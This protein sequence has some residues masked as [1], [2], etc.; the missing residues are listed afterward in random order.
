MN[1]RTELRQRLRQQAQ[2]KKT[3]PTRTLE[4]IL[5]WVQ[6]ALALT[7]LATACIYL[8]GMAWH[9]G[10]VNVF[11]VDSSEFPLSTEQTLLVGTIALV[12]NIAPYISYPLAGFA[13][14]LVLLVIAAFTS[15]LLKRLYNWHQ[16]KMLRIDDTIRQSSTFKMLTKNAIKPQDAPI[17]EAC[18]NIFLTLFTRYSYIIGTG[19]I[20]FL[21]TIYSFSNGK[22]EA[23]SQ[24]NKMKN[25]EYSSA[26]C[27]KYAEHPEE[28]SALRIVCNATQCTFWTEKDGTIY[29]RHDQIVSATIP[30]ATGSKKFPICNRSTDTDLTNKKEQGPAVARDATI[31]K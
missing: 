28:I 24:I 18:L 4:Q 19:I 16:L 7:P 15:E 21:L 12:S 5:T 2:K 26:N 30:P 3:S 11:H 27:L 10:Y 17:F 22:N 25:K 6:I 1:Q 8:F 13:L 29:L 31:R 23:Q 20:I 14:V 9:T